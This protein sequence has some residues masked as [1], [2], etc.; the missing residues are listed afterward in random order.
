MRTLKACAARTSVATL[1]AAVACAC[2]EPTAAAT[3][4]DSVASADTAVDAC[5]KF[6]TAPGGNC[7]ASGQF[8]DSSAGQCSPVGPPVCA[9]IAVA[10]PATCVPRWCFDWRDDGDQ[11]CQANSEGCFQRGRVCAAAELGAAGLA[12]TAKHGSGPCLPAGLTSAPT[13][14]E[15]EAPDW[16]PTVPALSPLEATETQSFC[17][18]NTSLDVAP[19]AVGPC[20]AATMPDPDQASGCRAVGVPWVC[21]PGFIVVSP[22]TAAKP[23]VCT[24]DPGLCPSTGFGDLAALP[25]AVFVDGSAAVAGKGTVDAPYKSLNSAV[26]AAPEGATIVVAAG[27]YSGGVDLT[28]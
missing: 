16:M 4:A 19:C 27:T 25:N 14:S 11:V 5:A 8:W 22:A 6:A 18:A 26:I 13:A 28:K 17:A 12:G 21:P 23:A 1:L 10:S 7:C 24:P 2:G 9:S 15:S 20:G 3:V